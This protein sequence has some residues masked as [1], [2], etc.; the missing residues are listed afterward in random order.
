KFRYEKYSGLSDCLNVTVEPETTNWINPKPKVG[1]FVVI[2]AKYNGW[3]WHVYQLFQVVM[4]IVRKYGKP[5][6]F[7]TFTVNPHWQMILDNLFPGWITQDRPDICWDLPHVRL[8]FRVR[9]DD[10]PKRL[11][12]LGDTN[13]C[14][15]PDPNTEPDQYYLV[16]I[17]FIHGPFD[18]GN[19][20]CCNNGQC[21][22]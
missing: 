16:G 11:E 6:Y 14:E 18:S 17:Q 13:Q 20:R 4:A 5:V 1:K 7:V 9:E 21:T 22:K 12:E 3:P 15:Q 8:L 10:I 2:P 19:L